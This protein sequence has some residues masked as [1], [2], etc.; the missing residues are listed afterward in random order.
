MIDRIIRISDPDQP[1][2]RIF[3]L[4]FF[5]EAIRTKNMILAHSSTW[6]DPYEL[7]GRSIVIQHQTNDKVSQEVI[8]A[9]FLRV[10]AQCWSATKESDTL[11]RAYSRVIKDQ[12][13]RRNILPREEG[14]RVSTSARKLLSALEIGTKEEPAGQCYIGTVRYISEDTLA[15]EVL[16]IFIKSREHV[17]DQ[18]DNLVNFALLKRG[19]FSHEAEV[20]LIFISDNLDPATKY[21]RVKIDPNTLFDE[22]TFDPRL[23]A[24]ERRE[25]EDV[26]RKLGYIGKIVESNLYQSPN[27]FISLPD[28]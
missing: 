1:I 26:I 25:R 11:L 24:F 16:D 23:E 28:E 9:P 20:R 6:E 21:I 27:L 5:E 18:P 10:F 7:L 17:F 19:A 12:H 3:S 8:D 2:Y 22:V 15:Q 4:W 13:V 14:V